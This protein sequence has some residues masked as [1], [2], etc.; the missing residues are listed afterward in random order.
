MTWLIRQSFPPQSHCAIYVSYNLLWCDIRMQSFT[1]LKQKEVLRP[2]ID[3]MP[4]RQRAWLCPQWGQK[5]NGSSQQVRGVAF[6]FPLSYS[7]TCQWSGFQLRHTRRTL[8]G[9]LCWGQGT[10]KLQRWSKDEDDAFNDFIDGTVRLNDSGN[11]VNELWLDC[12][13]LICAEEK[14]EARG[15]SNLLE[16]L[17]TS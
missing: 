13:G 15:A 4:H 3:R 14:A 11:N 9:V 10:F 16:M 2:K 5:F 1:P 6:V 8:L 7:C 12:E 17:V